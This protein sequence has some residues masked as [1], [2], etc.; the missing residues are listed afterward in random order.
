MIVRSLVDRIV[1][2]ESMNNNAINKKY[3]ERLEAQIRS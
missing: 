2:G 1:A 3:R